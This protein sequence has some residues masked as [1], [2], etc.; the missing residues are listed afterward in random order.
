MLGKTDTKTL[1]APSILSGDFANM[2]KSV[3]DV[4]KWGA[5]LV[6]IDVMDGSFV[7]NLTFGMPMVKALRGYAKIPFDV[8]LMICNP[9][10]YL[11]E[12]AEGGA[13]ILSF[14]PDA[15]QDVENC[16][17]IIRKNGKKCGL[18]LNPD[19]PLSMVEKYLPKL[20]L[21]VIMG[22]Y[23]GFGGQKLIG[24]TADKLREAKKL[25]AACNS[26]ALLEIDGGV[27]AQNAAELK[28][29]GADILVA[30]SAVFSS[31]DPVQTVRELKR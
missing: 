23:A 2:G 31:Q 24:Q 30:G 16:L 1:I 22:V 6:H 18:A 13:D 8:H 11:R 29:A 21:L 10:K 19:K 5:D 26:H 17:E 12:F 27:T 20:D 28:Q 9:E 25:I 4:E 3:R 7:P 15:T 14:H